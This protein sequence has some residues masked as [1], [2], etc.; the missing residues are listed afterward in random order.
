MF[1]DLLTVTHV[2]ICVVLILLVLLQ[3]GKG[4]DVGATFGG[5]GNSFFGA[6]GADNLLSRVTK[7]C[8][9]AFMCTSVMLAMGS[10]KVVVK[11]SAIFQNLPDKAP[12]AIEFEEKSPEKK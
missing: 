1:S 12:G 11:E 7:I 4:A 2:F 9:L 6:S 5:G 3:Q 8:A 10:N